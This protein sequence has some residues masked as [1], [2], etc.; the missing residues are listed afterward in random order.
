MTDTHAQAAGNDEPELLRDQFR[1][2]LRYRWLIGGGI[3][4]GLVGG[5]WLGITSADQY[6][7]NSD[8]MLRTPTTNPFDTTTAPDK[9]LNT[10]TERQ[11]A[12]STNVAEVAAEKLGGGVTASE[13]K[14]NFQ[15]TNPPQSLTLRFTYTGESPSEAARRANALTQ[16]YLVTRE[17]EWIKL[18]DNMVVKLTKQLNPLGKKQNQIAQQLEGMTEGSSAADAAQTLNVGLKNRITD[19]QS[20]IDNLKGLDMSAGNVTQKATPPGSA[21][22]LGVLMSLALGGAVGVALGLLGAWARLI[23]DPSPRSTG[24]VARAVRAPVLG[25]LPRGA[26]KGLLTIDDSR[27][28][29]EYRSVA[30]RLAYDHR[31]ADR[32]RLLV[33]AARSASSQAAAAVASNLAASF[34]ETGKDVLLIEGDLRTPALASRLRTSTAGRPRW[35]LPRE[36]D[37]NGWPGPRPL[38]VDAGESGTFDLV[39]GERVR[40]VARALTS[41][42]TTQLIEGADE[43]NATV[44]V[45]APP[46]LAYA[47]ALALVD[48]VDGVLIVCDMRSVHRT[49]L[50]RIRELIVGAGG[51]VLGAV[52]H[53]EDDSPRGAGRGKSSRRAGSAHSGGRVQARPGEEQPPFPEPIRRTPRVDDGSETVTLR[54]VRSSDR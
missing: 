4:I 45:L 38:T 14:K 6:P 49:E 50:S 44:V 2:L 19:L 40:N 18:R 35:S 3:G 13:L 32:R 34:A 26:S 10:N 28:A 36:F 23:F 5:A 47:D 12:L 17:K 41:T 1:Q 37:E 48:R 20:Q 30:F 52:T 39:P 7:A 29:E 42:R 43:A 22:G 9:A 31:F 33:V 51:T 25:S 15:V 53:A 21:D 11:N 54:T 27:T 24:D 8:V 46:V 16:A